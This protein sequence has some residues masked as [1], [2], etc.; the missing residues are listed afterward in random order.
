MPSDMSSFID[1]MAVDFLMFREQNHTEFV[2]HGVVVQCIDEA[3]RAAP[4]S[5]GM[6]PGN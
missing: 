5:E 6:Q 1:L 3:Y 4:L 2:W